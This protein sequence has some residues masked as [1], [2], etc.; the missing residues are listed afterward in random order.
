MAATDPLAAMTARIAAAEA[1]MVEAAINLGAAAEI[2]LAQIGVG[3]ILAAKILP[4]QNGQDLIEIL[5]QR[6][7]AQL[8]PGVNPGETLQLQVT[9]FSGTQIYVRNLGTADPQTAAPANEPLP[10]TP[11]SEPQQQTAPVAPPR[12]VFVAA[13]VRQSPPASAPAAAAAPPQLSQRPLPPSPEML[14]VE[15]RIAAA[16][17]AKMPPPAALANSP[18]NAGAKRRCAD[19]AERSCATESEGSNAD[20]AGVR[21]RDRST[22]GSDGQR[23]V[24]R[25]AVAG[26]AVYA[27]GRNGRAARSGAL[28]FGLAAAGGGAAARSRRRAH[29][30]ASNADRFYGASESRQRRN[31][32]R[33]NFRLRFERHRRPRN[34][35]RA[36]AA[37]ARSNQSGSS[38]AACAAGG[39]PRKGANSSKRRA[40]AA[41]ISRAA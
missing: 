24:A 41:R 4:P 11:Q 29:S 28:A 36:A 10:Q 22:G 23:S 9:E 21:R 12:E 18:A 37:G 3:D 8:P 34:E 1:A 14:R 6:V 33:A 15:A 30:D 19:C 16:Q 13:S 38:G 35:A 5:G 32:S 39:C 40:A 31:A 25:R 26:H 20:P 7:A 27:N 2:L 17:A